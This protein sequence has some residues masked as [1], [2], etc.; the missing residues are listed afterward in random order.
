[1]G[2]ISGGHFN[3]AVSVMFFLNNELKMNELFVYIV[4]Q[5]LGAVLAMITYKY[6]YVV[7][8]KK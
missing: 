5:L 3:P 1:M 7:S 2:K 8:N 6:L 4:A